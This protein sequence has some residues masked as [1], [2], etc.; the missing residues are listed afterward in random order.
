MAPNLSK[1]S[2]V[3]A[4]LDLLDKVGLDG[5]T[6]RAL[7]G[8]LNVQAPALYWHVRDKQ[9]LLDEMATE[10]WRRIMA[11]MSLLPDDAPWDISMTMFGNTVRTTLL[12]LRDGAKVFSGTYLTDPELLR[13]REKSMA[14]MIEQG[15]TLKDIVRALS[16]VYGFT[17]GFCIEE[18]AVAQ[19]PDAYS[20]ETRT[21]SI[22]PDAPL[23][24][25]V[26]PEIFSD[27]D[28]RY[29]DLLSIL[30]NA[31]SRMRTPA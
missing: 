3:L 27:P 12:K 13:S 5:L 14:S 21:R 23:S 28:E 30:I 18:Q 2:I 24:V 1:Q 29:R 26:G 15:F 10:L 8:A 17:I 20:L 7:A 9:H 31:I 16:L 11:T 25:E 4:A 6:V 19:N 22:G